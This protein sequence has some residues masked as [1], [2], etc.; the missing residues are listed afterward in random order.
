MLPWLFFPSLFR[1][2]N[3]EA[4]AMQPTSSSPALSAPFS[5]AAMPPFPVATIPID[6]SASRGNLSYDIVV[7]DGVLNDVGARIAED[8]GIRR[9]VVITDTNVEPLYRERLEAVLAAAGHTVLQPVTVP[10]GESSKNY[11]TLHMVL[12][13]ILSR[14]VDRKTVIV[15]LGGGVVGDLAGLAASMVMRGLDLVQVPTSLLAQVDSSVGGKTGIDTVAGKNTVGTFYQPR[16]VI[17]DVSLLDSLPPREMR[18]GY[19]EIVKYGLILDASFFSWCRAHGGQL[20]GGDRE[21]QIQ[22]IA[23]SCRYKARI[24]AEDERESGPRALLN[25]GHTFGH[26]L[27]T[28]TGYGNLLLHGEAVA[29]GM[30]MAFHVSERLG[31]C[32]AGQAM[33]VQEHLKEIGLPVMPP[34]FSYDI[35]R[36]MALMAQDKK[37]EH[38]RLTLILAKDIGKAFVSTDVDAGIIRKAWKNFLPGI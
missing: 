38:G 9:C 32:P 8:L 10:A 26:A 16:L 21:A 17:A 22:A 24:V 2:S 29:I 18:A 1:Q 19:A 31:L 37:A 14:G 11:S 7:G 27:E 36:L 15:A 30:A 34:P 33:Q 28:A 35:D 25:L 4:V 23:A 6:V 20:L 3:P 13:N 5:G 12:E